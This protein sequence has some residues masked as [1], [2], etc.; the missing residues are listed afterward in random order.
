MLN[1][2]LFCCNLK[3]L[4]VCENFHW[5]F[6]WEPRW[7]VKSR[8]KKKGTK[9]EMDPEDTPNH[10]SPPRSRSSSLGEFFEKFVHNYFYSVKT[11]KF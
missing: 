7:G 8:K 9:K 6:L 2:Q 4:V 11:T 1:N 5:N 3:N 10:H